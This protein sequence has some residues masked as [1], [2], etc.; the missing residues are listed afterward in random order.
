M[1]GKNLLGRKF[2]V[3]EKVWILKEISEKAALKIISQTSKNVCK[4]TLKC[5][6]FPYFCFSW[7]SLLYP[8]T[9]FTVLFRCIFICHMSNVRGRYWFLIGSVYTLVDP[10]DFEVT[11]SVIFFCH[12]T[13][14]KSY[15]L[16]QETPHRPTHTFSFTQQLKY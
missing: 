1:W 2:Q 11:K 5:F 4:L 8:Q 15:Q 14:Q 7:K 12:F 3:Q 9:K 6:I 13:C 10:P 16:C